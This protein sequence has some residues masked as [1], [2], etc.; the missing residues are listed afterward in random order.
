[1]SGPADPRAGVVADR[2]GTDPFAVHRT[3]VHVAVPGTAGER[4]ARRLVAAHTTRGWTG[5][6]LPRAA[7]PALPAGAVVVVHGRAM[8]GRAGRALRRRVPAGTALLWWADGARPGPLDRLRARGCNAVVVTTEVA[9]RWA[10]RVPVPLL[11]VR[12]DRA[13]AD[14]AAAFVARA[15]AFGPA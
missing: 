5:W 4:R 2:V 15:A 3:V 13:E 7:V 10:T 9:S 12:E 1:M 11:R 14:E 6:V 8:A